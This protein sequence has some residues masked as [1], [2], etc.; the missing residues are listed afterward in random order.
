MAVRMPMMVSMVPSLVEISAKMAP[1]IDRQMIQARRFKPSTQA[2]THSPGF[3]MPPR[4][5]VRA[6][7]VS[8][9]ALILPPT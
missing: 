9:A 8:R 7:A 3:Q 6:P 1:V 2:A 4:R 5:R